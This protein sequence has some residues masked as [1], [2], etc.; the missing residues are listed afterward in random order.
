MKQPKCNFGHFFCDFL[1]STFLL[2][3]ILTGMIAYGE[4]YSVVKHYVLS[5]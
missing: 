5:K 4:V 2:G 3:C 1:V